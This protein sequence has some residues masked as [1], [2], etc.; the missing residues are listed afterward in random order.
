[1]RYLL[2]DARLLL[3][4]F[5]LFLSYEP[6]NLW[7]VVFFALIPLFE[8]LY[9]ERKKRRAFTQAFALSWLFSLTT[10]Y[11]VAYV[12]KQF[13]GLNWFFAIFL[14]CIFAIV[15]QPQFYLFALPI[16]SLLQRWATWP[17]T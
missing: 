5:L 13:G 12:L 4:F 15:G 7:P 3:A 9:Q 11:W 2:P 1:M 17:L 10:F 14:L 8:Y 16:R 6:L